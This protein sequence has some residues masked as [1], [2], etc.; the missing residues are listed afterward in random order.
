[1]TEISR[2][3]TLLPAEKLLR[4]FLL[5][6]AES[7]PGLEIWVTGGWVRD[8]LLGIPSSDLDLSLS[9]ITG[10]EFGAFLEQF[11]ARPEVM[12]RYSRRAADLGS[13]DSLFTKFHIM[14]KNAMMSKQLETAGGRL[15]GLDVDMVNLRKELYSGQSRNPDMEFGTAEEDAFR[16]DATVNALFFHLQTQQVVDLT[17]RGLKDLEAKI[18]RTPLDPRQTFMDDPLRVLRLIRIAS[19]LGFAIDPAASAC[20]K[21]PEIHQLLNTMITRDRVGDELFK[22]MKGSHPEVAFQHMYDAN[23]Y[24]PIFIRLNSPLLTELLTIFPLP[25]ADKSSPWPPAWLQSPILLSKILH[26]QG[27]LAMLV[28]CEKNIDFPWAMAAYAPLAGLRHSNLRGAVQEAANAIRCTSKISQLLEN[29]LKNLDSIDSLVSLIA[30]ESNHTRRSV[31][32]MAVRSWGETWTTQVLFALLSQAVSIGY[33]ELVKSETTELEAERSKREALLR[34]YTL[35]ADFVVERELLDAATRRPLLNGNEIQTL[36]GLQN[37]GRYLKGVLESLVEWQFDHVDEG[38]GA[39]K[40]WLLS[41]RAEL[42][43]PQ[44]DREAKK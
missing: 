39:A 32:G 42:L 23:L 43:P 44:L 13:P 15:F 21:D 28:Q 3:I 17:G 41:S 2:E 18:M 6:C 36:F 31:V 29:S 12:A 24:A 40:A 14:K 16:R 33:E 25:S 34:K 9:H 35:F 11:S 10:K 8:R 37:G 26:Q 22:M 7:F 30:A 27:N 20:M 1:M 4:E 5:E 38:V 19:R